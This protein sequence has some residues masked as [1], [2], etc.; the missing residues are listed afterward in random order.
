MSGDNAILIGMATK[1][2]TGKTRKK[3]I[4]FGVVLATIL[5]IV[6]AFF[7]VILL[8]IKG[9]AFAGGLLLLWVVWKFYRDVRF[10]SS[11]HS[12]ASK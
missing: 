6:L 8:S 12:D 9:V 5:R 3:A 1:N 11:H 10:P 2:L 7:A 4:L